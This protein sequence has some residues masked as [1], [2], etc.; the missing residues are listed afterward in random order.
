M[1]NMDALRTAIR[2]N[3]QRRTM[4]FDAFEEGEHSVDMHALRTAIR[5]NQQRR[6][7]EFDAFEG[8]WADEEG[9]DESSN[10]RRQR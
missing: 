4:G 2:G 10:V 7:M 1:N 8:R 9:K 3:Q 6:A 5:G